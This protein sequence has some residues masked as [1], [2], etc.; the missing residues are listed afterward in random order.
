MENERKLRPAAYAIHQ[1]KPFFVANVFLAKSIEDAITF[2]KQEER[3]YYKVTLSEPIPLFEI[4][5]G[6]ELRDKQANAKE[7]SIGKSLSRFFVDRKI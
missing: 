1:L 5:S 6:W 2:I 7:V 4:P 3:D